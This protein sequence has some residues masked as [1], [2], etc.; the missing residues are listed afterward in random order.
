MKLSSATI[1]KYRDVGVYQVSIFTDASQDNAKFDGDV[2]IK[3]TGTYGTT[4]ELLLVNDSTVRSRALYQ[5]F[6]YKDGT[7]ITKIKVT[8]NGIHDTVFSLNFSGGSMTT[9][10]LTQ[11][12]IL[13][14]PQIIN[15]DQILLTTRRPPALLD[16]PRHCTQEISIR[17]SL[18]RPQMS[19]ISHQSRS[20]L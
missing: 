6:N 10:C 2:Y 3:L 20:A 5:G 18:L 15:F 13:N 1:W 19:E 16:N 17:T 12:P 11:T 4:D 14:H 9:E 8:L 7:F